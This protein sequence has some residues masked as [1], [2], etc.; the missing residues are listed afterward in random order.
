[1]PV[2]LVIALCVH[3]E[4]GA[5]FAYGADIGWLSQMEAQ[6]F[7]F[8]N[9][10]GVQEN[11]LQI[12]KEHGI[13]ALRFR[14]WVNPTGG[15]CGTKDVATMA[16]RAKSMGFKI[17]LDF[18]LAD[19]WADPQKQPLPECWRKDSSNAAVLA[20]DVYNHIY[21]V[22]DTIKSIGVTPAWVQIG[23]ETNDGTLWET[24]RA[25]THM[26]NFA[27]IIQSGYQAV[28]A[29]D[30]SIQVVVHVATGDSG[31][32]YQ[33]IFDGLKGNGTEWDIIGMSVYPSWAKVPWQKFD[34]LILEKMNDMMNRYHSKVM[35][36][37]T[38]Y[39]YHQPEIAKNFLSDLIAKVQSVDGLGVFY[40]E[41]EGYGPASPTYGYDLGAWNWS[42]KQP[43]AAM[44]AFSEAAQTSKRDK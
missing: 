2:F 23:N 22:L 20:T 8:Y 10:S 21:N 24:C 3:Q 30:T 7:K 29:V 41:P 32:E 16:L 33:K 39:F 12:L 25:S 35:V 13:N 26:R 6:G 9:D 34:S 14:V 5:Q 11:C 37:E 18:H 36:V 42:T 40:W 1:V 44:D 17:M 43:T 38:G 28:K 27:S 15:W 19:N 4:A 31:I